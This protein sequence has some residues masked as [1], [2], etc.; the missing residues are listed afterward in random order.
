V[1]PVG[2]LDAGRFQGL[3]D[4]LQRGSALF[5]LSGLKE[6]DGC[7]TDSGCIRKL[8]LIPIKKAAGCSALGRGKHG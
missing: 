7:D 3:R 4:Q 6:A 1:V 5:A 8:L 2:Q